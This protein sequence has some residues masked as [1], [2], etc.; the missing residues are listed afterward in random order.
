MSKKTTAINGGCQIR[1]VV[2]Y[3][4]QQYHLAKKNHPLERVVNLEKWIVG[5]LFS[6]KHTLYL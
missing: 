6:C 1:N 3:Q 5:G 4:H 2:S